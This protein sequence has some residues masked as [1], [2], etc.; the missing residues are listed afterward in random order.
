MKEIFTEGDVV[1]PKTRNA[2][3]CDNCR[4]SKSSQLV[5][6]PYTINGPFSSQDRTRIENA[7]KAFHLSTCVRFIPQKHQ[8]NYISIVKENGC[9][10]FVGLTGGAQRLS[11][12]DGCVQN[13]IIQ[14]ELIHALGFWHEQ[15]RTDRD[16]YVKINYE[17]I[18]SGREDNFKKL[19]T[20]NLNVP[21]D[22]SS[23]MHYGPKDFS[24][25]EGDT[26]TAFGSSAKIGQRMGMSENDILKINKLYGCSKCAA[27]SVQGISFV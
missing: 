1:V 20:N 3:V 5:Q 11:L 14:H 24:K 12:G 9:W 23:V 17:N 22:Y 21:Y 4:W 7:M 13:G 10:S 6:V 25:N 8:S 26:I 27:N 19:E 18:Q 15:S 16:I 2:K